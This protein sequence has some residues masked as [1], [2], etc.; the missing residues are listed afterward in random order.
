[1]TPQPTN[2]QLA[3]EKADD[4]SRF[5]SE[6]GSTERV[7]HRDESRGL[8]T[9]EDD[10]RGRI[11]IIHATQERHTCAIADALALRLRGH[12]F[13]VEIGDACTGTMPPPEDY[14]IVIFGLPMTFGRES[15]LIAKYVEQNRDGLSD[16]PSALF[17]VSKSGTIRD[18]DPGGFLQ[19]FL[20][21]VGW[22]PALAAAFAGGEPF[23]REGVMVRFA[24]WM[25]YPGAAGEETALRTNWTDV[26]RFADAIAVDLASHAV[27]AERSDT[28]FVVSR[29]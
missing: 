16:V 29:P 15:A 28:H 19:L 12:G 25:G 24:T 7:E 13:A 20:R 5:E 3:A 4:L 9:R 6:G 11:L 21:T 23:P 22:Q 17:T 18:R 27:T 1:M 10:Q 14:D 26:E 8:Q 2:E